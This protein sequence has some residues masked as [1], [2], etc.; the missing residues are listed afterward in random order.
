[1]TKKIAEKRKACMKL[2]LLDFHY[3]WSCNMA[4]VMR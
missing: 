4:H 1:M 2:I 3:S